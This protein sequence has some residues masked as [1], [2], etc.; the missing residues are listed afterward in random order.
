MQGKT[1]RGVPAAQ[2]NGT[3][4]VSPSQTTILGVRIPEGVGSIVRCGIS[5]LLRDVG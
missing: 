1:S 5:T 4:E 2:E 3:G